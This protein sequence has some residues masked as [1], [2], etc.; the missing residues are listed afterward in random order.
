MVLSDSETDHSYKKCPRCKRSINENA[1]F[2]GQCGYCLSDAYQPSPPIYRPAFVSG[3]SSR[4]RLISPAVWL[5]LLLLL[6]NLIVGLISHVSDIS[7]P[8]FGFYIEILSAILIFFFCTGS[9]KPI[10]HLL[11]N[12]GY[13]DYWSIVEVAG[14]IIFIYIFMFF[15]FYFLSL[16]GVKE[17]S[18]LEY[19]KNHKWPIWSAFILFCLL[20]GVF[21]ELAFRG[22]IM[23]KLE[24]V[25]R[26]KEALIVQ[27]AMFSILH[28]YPA[29]F[30]SHFIIGFILGFIRNRSKNLYPSMVVHTAWNAIVILEEVGHIGV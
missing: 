3:G 11:E 22:Y 25:C 29:I 24:Q 10:K 15:Y 16:I 19:F 26:P 7:S 27:A 21:E 4:W 30:I 20:P 17:I 13:K 5:W 28:M 14:A 9:D 8:F 23:T 12:S 2:C 6:I 18:Y 1:L